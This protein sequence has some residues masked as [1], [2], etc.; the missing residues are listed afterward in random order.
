M[1]V[2]Q[3]ASSRFP[4][5]VLRSVSAEPSRRC[6]QVPTQLFDE[7]SATGSL[8]TLQLPESLLAEDSP[9]LKEGRFYT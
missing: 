4:G 1:S 9:I 2:L 8:F 5:A 6:A 3:R 7:T